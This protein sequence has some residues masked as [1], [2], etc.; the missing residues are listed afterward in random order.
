MRPNSGGRKQLERRVRQLEKFE[1][2]WKVWRWSGSR[3][4]NVIGAIMGWARTRLIAL[5]SEAYE[6]RCFETYS[7]K[8]AVAAV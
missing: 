5:A 4:H 1:R 3:L 6:A 8:P 2:A 7:T